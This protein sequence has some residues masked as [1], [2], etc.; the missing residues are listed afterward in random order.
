MIKRILY[1]V[2]LIVF[3]ASCQQP[4]HEAP[5]VVMLSV[6]GFRWDYADKVSTPNLDKIAKMG[7]KAESL[8]A[9][10]P[11]KTFPNH[12][13]MATGLYPD[14]HGIVLNSFYDPP[15]QRH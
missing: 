3:F 2:L 7:V 15:T 11:T 14:N 10:F 1:F 4:I 6:D 12:Y 9:S 13:S 8:K 5:Y